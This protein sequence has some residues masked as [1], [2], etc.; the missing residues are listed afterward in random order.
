[1]GGGLGGLS[2]DIGRYRGVG[3]VALVAALNAD[4][5]NWQD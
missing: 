4:Q 1:M 5:Q 2:S 3:I